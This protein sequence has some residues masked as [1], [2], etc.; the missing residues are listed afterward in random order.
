M[1]ITCVFLT[2]ISILLSKTREAKVAKCILYQEKILIFCALD[3]KQ[4]NIY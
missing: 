3:D 2:Q 4:K 1:A